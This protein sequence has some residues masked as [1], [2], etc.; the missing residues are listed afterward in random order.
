MI[1]V[2]GY[3]NSLCGDDGIGPYVVGCLCANESGPPTPATV[4]Y[5]VVRQLTPELVDPISRAETVIFVDAA[6]GSE[7]GQLIMRSLSTATMAP[8]PETAYSAFTHQLDPAQLLDNAQLLYGRRP[9]AY[10]Y[11]VTG[12]SFDLGASFSHAVEAVL[13]QLENTLK[14]RITLCTSLV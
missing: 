8:E 6:V 14:E 7:P 11:T 9:A 10:L 2:I 1:L 13:P 3:G 12:Q 5:L 4:T